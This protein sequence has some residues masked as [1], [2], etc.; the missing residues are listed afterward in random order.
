MKLRILVTAVALALSI[1]LSTLWAG[2]K[3]TLKSKD[4]LSQIV[5]PEGWV[6]ADSSNPAAAIEGR[7]EDSNAFVMVIIADRTDPY[8]TL[9]E[10]ARDRRNEVLSHLVKS[11]CTQPREFQ[12]NDSNAVQY[13]IHGTFAAS[14]VAFGYFLTVIE[15]KHHYIEVVGWS[16]DTAFDDFAQTL[17]D[18]ASNVTYTGEQ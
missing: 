3:V 9:S 10:F 14:K 2:E 18:A 11:K 5:L 13:E 6:A 12:W 1:H 17:R 4:G 7:D 15:V 8:A 16:V